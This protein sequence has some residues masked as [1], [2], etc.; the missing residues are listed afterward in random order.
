MNS[1]VNDDLLL[2]M[3]AIDLPPEVTC[4]L[5]EISRDPAVQ[6]VLS[7]ADYRRLLEWETSAA[8]IDALR[9]GFP[10]DPQG[11]RILLVELLAAMEAGKGPAWGKIPP[12]YF[13]PTMK[14]FSRFVS[15]YHVSYG[16]Y[17]FDRWWW[18]SRQIHAR[19]LRIGELE[20]EYVNSSEE[21]R[22]HIPSDADLASAKV[23]A[24]LQQA[25]ALFEELLPGTA[26]RPFTCES[27]LLSPILEHLLPA[28]SNILKFRQYF[29][30]TDVIPDA[31]DYLEWVYKI[32]AGQKNTV[33]PAALPE[34]TSLQRN[35]K[36]HLLLGGTVGN[37]IGVLRCPLNSSSEVC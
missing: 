23:E 36:R 17:G 3:R 2:L 5:W 32:A 9:S 14:C 21:I 16:E 33:D 13:L 1:D 7:S 12:P 24:S 22:I 19:L 37:G 15:E 35:M 4:R 34:N 26:S 10:E 29:S 18:V 6:A 31:D 27:W 30:L 28:D 25:A 8:A 20:Y 11:L